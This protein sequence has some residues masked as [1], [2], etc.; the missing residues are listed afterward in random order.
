M[1]TY[2]KRHRPDETQSDW[3]SWQPLALVLGSFFRRTW[4]TPRERRIARLQGPPTSLRVSEF[5]RHSPVRR[6]HDRGA[7]RHRLVVHWAGRSGIHRGR[8][9]TPQA[10]QVGT[11]DVTRMLCATS[12]VAQDTEKKND[13]QCERKYWRDDKQLDRLNAENIE[14]LQQNRDAKNGPR[15]I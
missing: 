14:H 5:V 10:H 3:Q 13:S 6:R 8:E 15:N 9:I 12:Q 2:D 7:H 4:S 1:M 11:E